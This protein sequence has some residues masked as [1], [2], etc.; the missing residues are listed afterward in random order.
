VNRK[1]RIFV[2]TKYRQ[3]P[4]GVNIEQHE[5]RSQHRIGIIVVLLVVLAAILGVTLV[6]LG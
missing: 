6:A 3:L 5:I 4:Y 1:D 2:K